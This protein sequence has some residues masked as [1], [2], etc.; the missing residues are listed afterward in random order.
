MQYS[1]EPVR[2]DLGKL[3]LY[4]EV[5]QSALPYHTYA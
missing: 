2:A 4:R 3:R 5:E 1:F